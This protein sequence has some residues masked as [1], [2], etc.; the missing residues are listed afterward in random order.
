MDIVDR[1]TR[2]RMMAAIRGKDT[3]PELKVRAYLFRA[4]LR[5]RVHSTKLPGRPDIVLPGFSSVVMV[6]GCFW[7]RHDGCMY[8]TTPASNKDVWNEKFAGNVRRDAAVEAALTELGWAVHKL[9]EC[10]SS[11]ELAL[12]ALFWRIVAH[13]PV[14]RAKGSR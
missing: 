11:D 1:P 13:G 8:C 5:Y 12:D 6:H 14:R 7:H 10:E 3:L 4:G 9:W 2:S